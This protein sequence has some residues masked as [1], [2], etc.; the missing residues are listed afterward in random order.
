VNYY[1]VIVTWLHQGSSSDP[2]AEFR[3]ISGPLT[4]KEAKR[5]RRSW[6]SKYEVTK[7][8]RASILKDVG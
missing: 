4:K 1:F 6:L 7:Y 8:Q 2:G 3:V 5:D